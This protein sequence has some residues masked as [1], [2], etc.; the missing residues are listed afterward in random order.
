[1]LPEP[2]FHGHAAW[3]DTSHPARFTE[4]K[5]DKLGPGRDDDDDEGLY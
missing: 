5:M 2:N 3:R 4:T 1:M